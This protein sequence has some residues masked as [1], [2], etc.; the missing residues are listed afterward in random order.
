MS[1]NVMANVLWGFACRGRLQ[2]ENGGREEINEQHV[3]QQTNIVRSIRQIA[4]LRCEPMISD[5][6][7]Q[8]LELA[9][10]YCIHSLYA[11]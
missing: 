7:S 1:V 6:N 4:V 5:L 9:G 11:H 2:R 10:E 8:F 3:S